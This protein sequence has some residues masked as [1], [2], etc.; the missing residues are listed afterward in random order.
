MCA[1]RRG[2]THIGNAGLLHAVIAVLP[3]DPPG[4]FSRWGMEG[5]GV[6]VLG[7]CPTEELPSS[8]Q[9]RIITSSR[10]EDLLKRSSLFAVACVGSA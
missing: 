3:G 1:C 6:S 8:L 2:S 5:E 7:S 10:L 9:H 4:S